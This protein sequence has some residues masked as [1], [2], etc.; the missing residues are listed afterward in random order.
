MITTITIAQIIGFTFLIVGLSVIFNTRNTVLVVEKLLKD[1]PSIWLSGFISTLFGATLL[2]FSNF[3][4]V[5]NA[6]IAILGILSFF[7]GISLLLFPR[8]AVNISRKIVS[9][10][11]I[12]LI[13][14][15]IIILISLF[16]IIASL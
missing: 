13:D 12:I 5:L 15:I 6:V 9:H 7:K 16:L 4:G 1:S 8:F 2:A 10:K 11:L 3:N 14:G